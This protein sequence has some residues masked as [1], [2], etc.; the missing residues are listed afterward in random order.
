MGNSLELRRCYKN[1][2]VQTEITEEPVSSGPLEQLDGV[3][4]DRK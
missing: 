4:T 2:Q 3:L 1:H